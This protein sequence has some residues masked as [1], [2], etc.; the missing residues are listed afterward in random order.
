M[1]KLVLAT[2]AVLSLSTGTL[3]AK[4]IN[5]HNVLEK[6]N[7][8]EIS[9][10]INNA[11]RNERKKVSEY[12]QLLQHNKK[13]KIIR[14]LIQ[15]TVETTL[16][17]K[18]QD[19]ISA[20]GR[21]N[22]MLKEVKKL[23]KKYIPIFARVFFLE[24]MGSIKQAK[25]MLNKVKHMIE[26]GNYQ[27]ASRML[28]LLKDEMDILTLNFDPVTFEKALLHLKKTVEANNFKEALKEVIP[29]FKT[30]RTIFIKETIYPLGIIKAGALIHDA[31]TLNMLKG[32]HSK[33]ILSYIKEAEEELKLDDVLGYF[34]PKMLKK[35]YFAMMKI[36]KSLEKKV[37]EKKVV[38]GDEYKNAEK[39]LNSLKEKSVTHKKVRKT[40]Y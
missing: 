26:K 6:K 18:R 15:N 9:R 17:I 20:I 37:E 3:F 13:T 1:K 22:M 31:Y 21:I 12:N 27:E 10:K 23:D 5:G 16:D 28:A 36:L 38:K 24:Y 39:S 2:A 29:I 14:D 40:V 34:Y 30:G 19:K 7:A 32:K 4:Q 25:I 11:F 33:E 35:R 8:V